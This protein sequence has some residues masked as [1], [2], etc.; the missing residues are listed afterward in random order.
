MR[1]V[2]IALSETMQYQQYQPD[3]NGSHACESVRGRH[4][5]RQHLYSMSMQV[6]A[7]TWRTCWPYTTQRTIQSKKKTCLLPDTYT[8]LYLTLAEAETQAVAAAAA[9]VAPQAGGRKQRSQWCCQLQH[10]SGKS[11]RLCSLAS[12]CCQC[13]CWCPQTDCQPGS[14][15]SS[16]PPPGSGAEGLRPHWVLQ[17]LTPP[18]SP[19]CLPVQH[20]SMRRDA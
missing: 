13:Q 6:S 19:A 1:T 17:R 7:D 10:L 2:R 18:R 4:H 8:V 9:A 16:L 14:C 15:Q 20:T 5:M 11:Y 12:P 3:E